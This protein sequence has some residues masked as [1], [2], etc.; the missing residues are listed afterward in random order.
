MHPTP[1]LLCRPRLRLNRGRNRR[2]LSYPRSPASPDQQ[3][4]H[5]PTHCPSPPFTGP[6][7]AWF[8]RHRFSS[9]HPAT[10]AVPA[11]GN[12][13]LQ[14]GAGIRVPGNA[15]TPAR[16]G[17]EP[18]SRSKHDSETP[19]VR[20]GPQVQ[21]QNWPRRI[22]GSRTRDTPGG[23]GLRTPRRG[24]SASGPRKQ[25][26]ASC[27]W[28]AVVALDNAHPP[29]TWSGTPSNRKIRKHPQ[30]RPLP[31][32]GTAKHSRTETRG[33]TAGDVARSAR[34]SRRPWFCSERAP[35]R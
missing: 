18:H 23:P 28:I 9:G 2:I 27:R 35:A 5:K 4:F 13:A 6:Q 21:I 26:W 17:E 8:G 1:H 15:T 10:Q 32:T 25:V 16:A 29:R 19:T 22:D 14:T 20:P 7:G 3:P 12:P 24:A 34:A 31:E 11:R 33:L 30:C